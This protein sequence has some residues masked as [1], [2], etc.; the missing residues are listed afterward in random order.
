[1]M[2]ALPLLGVLV[3]VV[4][5]LAV[6]DYH[7]ALVLAPVTALAASLAIAL[8]DTARVRRQPL[9]LSLVAPPV[10]LAAVSPWF[11]SCAAVDGWLFWLLGPAVSWLMGCGVG[12]VAQLLV[13]PRPRQP[14]ALSRAS[15]AV[16]LLLAT[17]I[18]AAWQFLTAPQVFGYAMAVGWIAGAIYEDGVA[19]RWP[20]VA[21]R[22]L[23][24]AL[25]AP[26]LAVWISSVRRGLPWNSA[27]L[28]RRVVR[29]R[30]VAVAI[31]LAVVAVAVAQL[32]AAPE[33]WR[34]GTDE[35]DRR[36]PRQVAIGR[37]ADGSP[38]AIAHMPAAAQH[39]RPRDLLVADIGFRLEQLQ[40]WFGGDGGTVHVYAWPSTQAKRRAMGA[41]R[42]EIAKPWL[43][44]VHVVL[45][46]YGA[47][48]LAHEMAHVFAAQW[49]PN[50]LGVPLRHG[51]LPDA[52]TIEGMAVA[53]EWPIRG[54][55]D[56]HQWARAARLLGKAP[57]LHKALSSAG[58]YGQNS[59]L[60][61][62]LAG[63]LLR[64]LR[65]TRGVAVLRRLY[66]DGDLE[67]A[68]GTDLGALEQAWLAFLDDGRLHPLTPAD[69]ERARARFEPPA[70]L[71]RPCALAVGRCRDRAAGQAAAG[72]DKAA[73]DL[74]QGL[75]DSLAATVD[76]E[77]EPAVQL[78]ARI[79]QAAAGEALSARQRLQ[80]TWVRWTG[81]P[82]TAQPNALQR[83]SWRMTQGD[84]AWQAGQADGA[85]EHWQ[86]AAALPI[87][88][89]ARR[90]V[91]IKLAL[92]LLPQARAVMRSLLAEGGPVRRAGPLLTA[93]HRDL[94]DH[95]L[96]TWLWAR[97]FLRNRGDQP[98]LTA[99]EQ[100]LPALHAAYPWTAREALRTVALYR[101]RHG[102]CAALESPH[103]QLEAVAWR[104][105]L[106]QRCRWARR[107]GGQLPTL[108]V[109]PDLSPNAAAPPSP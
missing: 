44:Q 98:A 54:G 75:E 3:L 85:A 68:T 51:W 53:A 87:S 24:V 78:S 89:A 26:L 27:T 9:W 5:G 57:P 73:R 32:R 103:L 88:E 58:F 1:M 34:I 33:G 30:A 97:W 77:V 38:A 80:A 52:W 39:A 49:A 91:E 100:V 55:L 35:V 11:P 90:I 4:A 15:V 96:A 46:D 48:V 102:D 40:R 45:P 6:A 86:S 36:L 76:G 93:L 16:A 106:L 42:V 56:P 70:L 109:P 67:A 107:H 43:R 92:A 99:L 18:P 14:R 19:V 17:C 61:Y 13:P 2:A 74:W 82:K 79:A 23:D 66:R 37:R 22:L 62:T 31:G 63:S 104:D 20:Y 64:W 72:N 29:E 47:S 8:A 21:F 95:P 41:D 101:A 28:L 60:A 69:I 12:V 65:D 25:W 59:E 71:Q 50:P 83:A 84:V 10:L 94:P 105:E 81:L 7:A 108:L